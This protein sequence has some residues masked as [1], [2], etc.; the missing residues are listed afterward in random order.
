MSRDCHQWKNSTNNKGSRL[1]ES[2]LPEGNNNFVK[3]SKIKLYHQKKYQ[4]ALT[5]MPTNQ[6]QIQTKTQPE[7][8][9]QPKHIVQTRDNDNISRSIKRKDA[10]KG[11][12]Q[13][14][15]TANT[16]KK[17]LANKCHLTKKSKPTLCLEHWYI[18]MQ[19]KYTEMNAINGIRLV[20]QY[21]R[22]YKKGRSYQSIKLQNT[23]VVSVT[24]II[25]Y[26]LLF[27]YLML[28]LNFRFFI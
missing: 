1:P 23:T 4:T 28:F 12:L 6:S 18:N 3:K 24:V 27:F 8:K 19:R 21:D 2:R 20:T 13:N 14:P 22:Q 7:T 26:F 17:K 5:K 9:S 11:K 15:P 25:C 10:K 16:P